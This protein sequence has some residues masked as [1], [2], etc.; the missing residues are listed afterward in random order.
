MCKKRQ[1]ALIVLLV[2]QIMNANPRPAAVAGSFYSSNSVELSSEMKEALHAT[3]K[4]DTQDIKAIIIPHAGY[5]FS[6]GV[7]ATAYATLS[8]KYKNIFIIGSSH[9]V[10]FDGAALYSIGNYETPL[11]EVKVNQTIVS[12]L[13]RASNLFIF[14]PEAHKKEHTIEVQLPFLQTIYGEDLSIVPIVIATQNMQSIK[15]IT[16]ALR[17]Y[18][19]DENLFVISSD[20]SHYPSYPHA[21]EVD[22]LTLDAIEKGSPQE[23]INALIK[24]EESSIAELKTSACGWTSILTLMFLTEGQNYKYELLEYKN[25]GDTSY[26]DKERVVGYGALRVYKKSDSFRLNEQEKEELRNLAKLSLYEATLHNKKISIDESKISAKLKEPLGAFVTLYKNHNLRGCI[27]TFEPSEPLYKIIINMA[28]AAAQHD[29][30]FARV[31]PEELEEIEI[32]ISV[33]TPRKKI[34]S[35]NEIVLGKHGI[36]IQKGSKNGTYLPHVA[37]QMHWSVE[38]FVKHC[39]TEKANIP[40]DEYKNADIYVYEALVF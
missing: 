5:V 21:N 23:F 1:L 34:N 12:A 2:S 26:G 40:L 22:K 14:H 33:L 19:N 3:K 31:T 10:S 35:I 38:E 11:G 16:E 29:P 9:H 15:T 4:F 13:M 32:E 7:A 24:N 18:F 30:R 27:G 28:I 17:P 8:K 37:T 6:G 39:A 25:S 20:L 36:Y